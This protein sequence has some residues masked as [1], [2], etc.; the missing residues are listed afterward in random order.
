MTRLFTFTLSAALIMSISSLSIAQE[1]VP[2]KDAAPKMAGWNPMSLVDC[3]TAGTLKRGNFNVIMQAYPNGGILAETNIGMSNRL[4][5]GIS[6]GASGIV[7]EDKP[8]WDPS[9]EFNLKLSL[10]D[11]TTIF[12]AFTV[13]FC[14]QGYGAYSKEFKRYDF[15]SKGFYGVGSKNYLIGG[16]EFGLHA[17]LNYSMERTDIDNANAFLGADSRLNR[18]VGLVA[19]YD[20]AA[21]DHGKGFGIGRGYLNMSIQWLYAENL[22]ME[23]MVKNINNNR[24]PSSS[25]WR[26]F[27]VTYVEHF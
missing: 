12:P 21:N 3:P 13:G 2:T 4:M 1:R 7:S 22:V 24:K 25:I 6:Y 14:S 27:R 18:D 23:F 8:T 26:G 10:I 15:K 9:I 5:L 16:R 20:F 11:E 17:G 19:E